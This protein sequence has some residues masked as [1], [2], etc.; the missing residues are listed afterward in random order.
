MI[1]GLIE[2]TS[3]TTDVKKEDDMRAVKSLADNL[4]LDIILTFRIGKKDVDAGLD[5]LK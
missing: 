3:E 2:S 4:D 1:F 5:P